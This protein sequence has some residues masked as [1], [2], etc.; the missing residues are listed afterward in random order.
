M[1][2]ILLDD[3]PRFV[4]QWVLF[5]LMSVFYVNVTKTALRYAVAWGMRWVSLRAG[6]D[7]CSAEAGAE[8]GVGGDECSA[9]A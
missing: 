3:M 9:E 4:V 6:G 2:I 8:A 5:L 1:Q 7:E